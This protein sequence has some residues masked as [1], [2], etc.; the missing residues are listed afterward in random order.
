LFTNKDIFKIEQYKELL[1]SIFYEESVVS[2]KSVQKDILS[3]KALW[4]YV[5]D[6]DGGWAPS[7]L[8]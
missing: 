4:Q 5:A 2:P 7:H 6:S 3:L 8:S 1:E